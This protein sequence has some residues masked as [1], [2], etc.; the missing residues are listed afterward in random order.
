[1]EKR[2]GAEDIGLESPKR[3]VRL[4]VI[5]FAVPKSLADEFKGACGRKGVTMKEV[6]EEFMAGYVKDGAA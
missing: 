3:D 5:Q 2:L 1:M 6:V 4:K